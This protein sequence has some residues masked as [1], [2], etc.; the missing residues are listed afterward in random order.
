M[1]LSMF[2]DTSGPIRLTG[3]CSV[4]F[5]QGS[6][7]ANCKKPFRKDPRNITYLYLV[8]SELNPVITT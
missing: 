8:G 7:L 4:G 1:P 2:S 3:L 6:N 5:G